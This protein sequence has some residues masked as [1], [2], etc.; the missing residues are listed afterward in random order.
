MKR[1]K[2]L[3]V[4]S[5]MVSLI[6]LGCGP[7]RETTLESNKTLVHRTQNEVWNKGNLEIVD[8]LFSED[9]VRHFPIGPEITGLDT[10][11]RAPD[12]P[13]GRFS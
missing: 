12:Q 3:L 6:I 2:R 1:I 13:Q 7:D 11:S 8:Q 5:A 4:A 9:F 10:I